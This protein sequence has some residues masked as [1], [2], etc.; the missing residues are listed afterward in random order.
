MK[1][2]TFTFMFILLFTT[3]FG[4]NRSGQNTQKGKNAEIPINTIIQNRP[5][6]VPRSISYQGLITKADG[7]PTET[8]SY[9]HLRAHET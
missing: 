5:E 4:Q 2:F 3:V 6:S 9:T 7:T 8:V 1:K